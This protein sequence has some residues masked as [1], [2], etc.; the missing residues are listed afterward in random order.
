M[1]LH[2]KCK[3]LASMIQGINAQPI[4]SKR[5]DQ[6]GSLD[7]LTWEENIAHVHE[8]I[9]NPRQHLLDQSYASTRIHGLARVGNRHVQ[10]PTHH[11]PTLGTTWQP[12]SKS[13]GRLATEPGRPIGS[14]RHRLFPYTY[15]H[16]FLIG[17]QRRFRV[18][19][20]HSLA[21]PF[22]E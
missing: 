8:D 11:E 16:C 21:A 13:W 5:K 9:I 15:W 4:T 1:N 7:S 3:K 6:K 14:W 18:N 12:L 22:Y 20:L 19:A 17:S 2:K 10:V